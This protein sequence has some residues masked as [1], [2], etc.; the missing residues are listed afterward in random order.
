MKD[1]VFIVEDDLAQQK[2]LRLHFEEALGN[3]EVR[4]FTKPDELIDNLKDKP[5]AIVLDHFF[6]DRKENGLHYL[7]IIKKKNS[8]TPVIY[9]TTNN[10]DSLKKEALKG[11]AS[12][13]IIKDMA[14][15][16]RLRTALDAI[17][18]KKNNK[19]FFKSLFKS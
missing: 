15:L 4:C 3:Y 8:S 7:Q 13:F 19:G 17:H 18:E 5:F 11:G 9:Y 10:D 14:S 16:V 12:E 1:L 2:L 6:A